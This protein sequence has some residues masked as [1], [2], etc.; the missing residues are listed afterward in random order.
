MC[1]FSEDISQP[2]QVF[3]GIVGV[4]LGHRVDGRPVGVGRVG[5]KDGSVGA[6]WNGG[7]LAPQFGVAS[8]DQML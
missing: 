5:T 1:I 8:L 4:R 6:V 7:E 2:C 3:F